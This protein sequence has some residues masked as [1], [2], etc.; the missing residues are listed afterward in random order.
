MECLKFHECELCERSFSCEYDKHTHNSWV[1]KTRMELIKK[2]IL[3]N[4]VKGG[5]GATAFSCAFAAKIASLGFKT[6]LIE[7]SLSSIMPEYLE[8]DAQK[9]LEIMMDGIVPPL[10]EYNFFYLSPSLFMQK[11]RKPLF[12][13]AEAVVK[14]I[15]KIII[16]T[17]WGE[18]DY[19]VVDMSSSQTGL[20]KEIKAFFDKKLFYAVVLVDFKEAES[21]QSMFHI[22][23]VKTLADSV[24]VLNSPSKGPKS[25]GEP[26][27]LPFVEELFCSGAKTS[28]VVRSI[29][30]PYGKV[31]EEVTKNCL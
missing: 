7:T 5:L 28:D 12:W 14:F 25:K 18:L 22:E 2:V 23:Y 21:A 27:D 11:E 3:V 30:K 4:S 1:R 6:G 16:N 26:N 17:N 10:S 20:L 29:M 13:D 31:L 24:C 9:G 19:L 8:Y 15:R